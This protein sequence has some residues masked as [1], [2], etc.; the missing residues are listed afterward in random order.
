MFD[1]KKITIN[2]AF[3]ELF[4]KTFNEDFFTILASMK[5]DATIT[6]L[7]TKKEEELTEDEAKLLFDANLEAASIMKTQT[8]RIAYIGSKLYRHDYK[9]SYLDYI[10]FLSTCE[11]SDFYDPEVIAAVWEKVTADQKVPNN[12]KN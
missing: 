7:R 5:P 11:S 4:Q 10:E 3:Y 9:C 6:K 12:V 2:A 1:T 8:A